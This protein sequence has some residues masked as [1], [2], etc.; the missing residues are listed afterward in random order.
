M[1]SRRVILESDDN[2]ANDSLL[3][4]EKRGYVSQYE[5]AVFYARLGEQDQALARLHKAVED[6]DFL[7]TALN[8]EPL[9]NSYR[10][11][12]RFVALVQRVGLAP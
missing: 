9:W 8:V 3:E 10:A 11:D 7:A 2:L 5:V 4:R 6:R 12:P 1:R